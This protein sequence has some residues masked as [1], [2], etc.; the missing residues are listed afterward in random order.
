MLF[1]L[2][3]VFLVKLNPK[4][5]SE[6]QTLLWYHWSN[7]AAKQS[8][9]TY[10]M[11]GS[12]QLRSGARPRSDSELWRTILGVNHQG[13]SKR[14]LYIKRKIRYFCSKLSEAKRMRKK[15]NLVTWSYSMNI[16]L[17]CCFTLKLVF[18]RQYS[19][20]QNLGN[21]STPTQGHQG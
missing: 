14:A 11:M 7:Y 5:D 8:G 1:S 12:E 17:I 3:R 21:T 15:V 19:T 16:V 4:L 10:K 13:T 9:L 6:T 2:P 18:S 20:L